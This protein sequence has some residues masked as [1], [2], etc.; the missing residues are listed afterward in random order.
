MSAILV[1]DAACGLAGE[2][3][4]SLLGRIG[5]RIAAELRARRDMRELAAL[6]EAALHDIGLA[7]GGLE[8]AV[9]HGRP[10]DAAFTRRAWGGGSVPAV[11]PSAFL[12]WR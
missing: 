4:P 1:H 10:L 5:R 9:R 8:D 6:D 12:E 2:R 7:P 11:T 3:R